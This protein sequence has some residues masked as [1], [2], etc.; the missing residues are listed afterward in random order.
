M[1]R[2]LFQD[3]EASVDLEAF[4]G[5]LHLNVLVILHLDGVSE[6]Q[7]QGPHEREHEATEGHQRVQPEH[8]QEAR[9]PRVVHARIQPLRLQRL[10]RHRLLPALQVVVHLCKK[11][12]HAL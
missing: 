3:L 8:D 6:Q 1:F 10:V 12:Q 7:V 2:P 9:D 11:Q 4:P 5:D